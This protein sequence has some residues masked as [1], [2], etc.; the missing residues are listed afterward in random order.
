MLTPIDTTRA[1]PEHDRSHAVMSSTAISAAPRRHRMKS[2][3]AGFNGRTIGRGARSRREH[4]R[5]AIVGDAQIGQ[6]RA[7]VRA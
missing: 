1:A 3:T 4:E 5:E 2:A 7:A 6:R